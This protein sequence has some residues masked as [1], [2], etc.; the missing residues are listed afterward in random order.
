MNPRLV[1]HREYHTKT[2]RIK[3]LDSNN[4]EKNCKSSQKKKTGY[5]QEA[6]VEM[7]SDFSFETTKPR[8]QENDIF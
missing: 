2:H 6:K 1:A 4:E 5:K 7:N 8:R 3:L